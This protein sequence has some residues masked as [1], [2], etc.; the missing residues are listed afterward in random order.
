MAHV[1][2][3]TTVLAQT[4][5]FHEPFHAGEWLLLDHHSSWAGRGRSQGAGT[6]FTAD[7]RLVA[8]FTQVNM[9]RDFP[10]GQAPPAGRTSTH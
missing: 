1:S 5:A 3:S 9:V 8:S 7:G 4:L 10:A 2:I 6:V